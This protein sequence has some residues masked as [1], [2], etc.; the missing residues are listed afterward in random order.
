MM[1][2]GRL[3]CLKYTMVKE[4][5]VIKSHAYASSFIYLL[6]LVSRY[7]MLNCYL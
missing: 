6:S 3:L 4:M 7:H 2:I 1:K 5:W